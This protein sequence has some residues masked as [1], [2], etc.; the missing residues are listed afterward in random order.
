[1]YSHIKHQKR[2]LDYFSIVYC[3]EHE[4]PLAIVPISYPFVFRLLL[5]DAG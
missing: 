1:M 3:F 2:K 4:I 5:G